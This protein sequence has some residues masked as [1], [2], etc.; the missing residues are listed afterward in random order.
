[1]EMDIEKT[2][3]YEITPTFEPLQSPETLQDINPFSKREKEA[4]ATESTI[5]GQLIELVQPLDFHLLAFPEL[6]KLSKEDREKQDKKVKERHL[7][8]LS[9]ENIQQLAILYNWG[10]CK[11]GGFIYLYNG[12]YW[13]KLDK[14]T[15]QNFLGKVAEKQGIQK[16]SAR[17]YEFREKLLKQFFATGFLK[18]PDQPE[19]RVL[20]NLINGT[21]EITPTGTRLRPFNSEDFLTYQLPFEY[22]PIARAPMFEAFLNKVLPD[23]DLQKILCEFLGYIFIKTNFLK[24][25]KALLLYGTGAN[26]KSVVYDIVNA[27]LGAMNVTSYSLENLTD[28]AGY[29]RA[30]IAGKLVNYASEINGKLETSFFKQLASGEPVEARLPYMEPF[31]IYDYAKLIFNLN[32]LPREV[33]HTNAYFRRLLIIPF[34][35]TISEADQDKQLAK[36]IIETELSG[37]FNWVLEGLKRLLQNKKFTES[38]A[39]DKAREAYKLESDS[40]A[41]FINEMCYKPST[42]RPVLLK[43]LYREYRAYCLEDGNQPVKKQNFKK[44]LQ[45]QGIVIEI[46]NTG[47]NVM[48]SN[49]GT[50]LHIG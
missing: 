45:G 8:I 47:N 24:L 36:K 5:L 30:M 34:E 26:G 43:E 28:K 41:L 46:L 42:K 16:F 15:L 35:V 14:E 2:T 6:S 33:E 31:I 3:Q 40:V 23:K 7:L 10:L 25:E 21:F 20:I 44:R 49:D 37:V 22:N 39:T 1:M 29:Y 48:I 13:V 38:Q 17:H 11:N 4:P 27:L 32:E 12:C 18:T 9:V 50:P 19:N